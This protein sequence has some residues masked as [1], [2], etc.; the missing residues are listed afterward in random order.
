MNVALRAFER[1]DWYGF[2]GADPLPDGS[3]P[4]VGETTEMTVVVSGEGTHPRVVVHVH[5]AERS[6]F[7]VVP[8]QIGC[9]L[10]ELQV[11]VRLMHGPT[12]RGDWGWEEI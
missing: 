5:V 11:Y 10:E 2:A 6:F 3:P 7:A 9:T 12:E 4:L 1:A 8:Q